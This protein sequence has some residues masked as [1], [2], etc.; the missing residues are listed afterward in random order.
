MIVPG[1]VVSKNYP[2]VFMRVKFCYQSISHIKWWM[3]R[4]HTFLTYSAYAKFRCGVA[5]L[6]IETGAVRAV[7]CNGADLHYM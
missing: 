7:G 6:R 4:F 2:N 5:P 3:Y 1:H